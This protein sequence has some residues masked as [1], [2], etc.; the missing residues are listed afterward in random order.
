MVRQKVARVSRAHLDSSK[1]ERMD[2]NRQ[3]DSKNWNA[4]HSAAVY[5][6]CLE[7]MLHGRNLCQC[8]EIGHVARPGLR[9]ALGVLCKASRR[10]S[11]DSRHTAA[12]GCGVIESTRLNMSGCLR[13]PVNAARQIV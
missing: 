1:I 5:S 6:D 3:V 2:Q 4:A 9:L 10:L 12:K 13:E 11:R 7:G 8:D